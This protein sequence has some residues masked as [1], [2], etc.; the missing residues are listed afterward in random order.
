MRANTEEFTID[1][2]SVSGKPIRGTVPPNFAQI[3][4]NGIIASFTMVADGYPL[5]RHFALDLM[6][7]PHE[8]RARK[9]LTWLASMGLTVVEERLMHRAIGQRPNMYAKRVM[10]GI[11]SDLVDRLERSLPSFA[12]EQLG[13]Y[14]HTG[15]IVIEGRLHLS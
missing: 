4:D 11:N 5:G 14:D 2:V 6:R 3:T 15:H 13:Y 9:V 7:N 10:W 12:N 8:A 1:V